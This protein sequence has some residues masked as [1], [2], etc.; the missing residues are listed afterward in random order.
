[1]AQMQTRDPETSQFEITVHA[2]RRLRARGI[3]EAVLATALKRPFLRKPTYGHREELVAPAV[4]GGKRAWLTVIVGYA[5]PLPSVVT[6]YVR[7]IP[8]PWVMPATA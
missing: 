2:Q 7:G 1:M 3:T 8:D 4:V 5:R 6:A